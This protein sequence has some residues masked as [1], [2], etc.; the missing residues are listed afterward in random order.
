MEH[1]EEYLKKLK[2]KRI[3]EYWENYY[4]IYYKLK[5]AI[6]SESIYKKVS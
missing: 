5:E 6:Q 2:T 3:N 4:K 1:S